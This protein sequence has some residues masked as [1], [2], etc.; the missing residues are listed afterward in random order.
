MIRRATRADAGA[1]TAIYNYY[2][3]HTVI[4]FEESLLCDADMALRIDKVGGSGLPWLVAEESGDV[5]GYAYATPWNERSAYR[6]TVEISA[7]V[8]KSF[9]SQG[10]G[11]RLY[12]ALFEELR[13]S[14]IHVV[15]GG[16]ALPNAAS[17]ALHEKF[18]MKKTAHF[19][20]VGFKFGEWVDVGYWQVRLND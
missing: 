7:Y 18:G 17:A 5:A 11:T 13:K 20:E 19:P 9:L 8:A 14:G 4:T 16:I 12:G 2:I 1:I 6:H 15:I 3:Q 10:L